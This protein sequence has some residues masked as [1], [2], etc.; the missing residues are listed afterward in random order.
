MS[1]PI[2]QILAD[3]ESATSS[4]TSVHIVASGL[5][6]GSALDINIK[7]AN[8][9]GGAGAMTANG[10]TFQIDRIGAKAYFEGGSSFWKHIARRS[11][12]AF[13]QLFAGRWIE[14]SAT[15]GQLA[16]LTT[17]TD[18]K[19]LFAGLLGSHGKLALGS[20]TT[21]DGQPAF[22][23]IDTTQGGTLYIAATGRPYPLAV[24][25]K[26]GAGSGSIM[27]EAWD[28]PVHLSAPSHPLDFTTLLAGK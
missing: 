1:K 27:F 4:A 5:S 24:T 13:I 16:P 10:L 2:A 21:I 11:S 20:K 22:G 17:F 12:N 26:H 19:T 7:L 14:A 8:G 23:L 15:S 28:Q 18:M 3:V 9:I 25:P 6:G